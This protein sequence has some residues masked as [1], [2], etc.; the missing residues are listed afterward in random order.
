M[1][2][3]LILSDHRGTPRT[4]GSAVRPRFASRRLVL[5]ATRRPMPAVADAVSATTVASVSID[6]NALHDRLTCRPSGVSWSKLGE[7]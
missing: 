6:K 4:R 5:L 2:R 1:G 3:F 7:V